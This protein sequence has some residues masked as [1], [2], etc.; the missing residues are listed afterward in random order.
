[1]IANAF[2]WTASFIAAG[3]VCLVG[4]LAWTFVDPHYVL[5]PRSA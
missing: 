5:S 1:V 2:G 4:A 3:A